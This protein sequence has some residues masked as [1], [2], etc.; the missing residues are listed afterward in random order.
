MGTTDF[1][2]HNEEAQA[3]WAAYRAGK[4]T[5]VPVT[6]WADARFFM[7]NEEINPGERV[8]FH[9][10]SE[11]PLVMMDF[12]L[13][14]A[15]W[16]ALHIAPH[17]DDQAGLPEKFAVTVDLQ[18][19]FDAAYFG[20]PVEYRSGQM[21]DTRPILAGDHKNLLFD[22]GLPDPLTGGIFAK[23]H[24]FC[25]EMSQR[26]QA[27]LTYLGR[28]V[29]F[30]PTAPFSSLF[31][32]D[33]PL[34]IA[35][36]LRGTELYEDFYSDPEYVHS[37]LDFITEGTIARFHAQRRF[38]GLPEKTPTWSYADDAVQMISTAMVRDFVIPA[39]LKLKEAL[40]TASR[41]SIH[42][43]GNATRHFK[44]FR[45]ALGVYSFDTGFPIDF[46]WVRQELG[47]EVEIVGGP[48]ITTLLQGTAD[49]VEAET[50]R[51]L[52]SGIREGGRFVLREA[53]DLAPGTPIQNLAAMYE[54][55]RTRG[56]YS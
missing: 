46:S 26:T 14:A 12:Q 23:A 21:P 7:L 56:S 34:T 31:G 25:E 20:A 40:T 8:S 37:L 30:D 17:C 41:I 1:Q 52:A 28:P 15:E 43:C 42:L 22:A 24:R 51:I 48:R 2:A 10:Y 35:T 4:P 29:E 36:N 39:H 47:P 50:C 18:R 13:R 53:N 16:R 11:D 49:Q 9:D 19:Y 3:V 45:D 33:G 32:T 38:F 5:R 27:G 44:L 54:T 55:A 6:L